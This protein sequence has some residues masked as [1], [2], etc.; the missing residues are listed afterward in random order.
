MNNEPSVVLSP[1]SHI[2]LIGICGTGMGA[3]AG[4]LKARGFSVSGSDA[5]AFPPMSTALMRLGI[6]VMEGF[7]AANLS[8]RPDL[9]VVGNVCR[10]DH[11]EAVAARQRGIPFASMA[12]VLRDLFLIHKESLVITGT[13]GKTTTTALTAF[14]LHRAGRDP[15]LLV[16]GVAADFGRGSLL[17]EGPEFVIEG[18]EYDSAYFEKFAKFL[19][20]APKAAVITSVE[21]DH[22]DIYPSFD[23]YRRAFG[24]FAASVPFP[25]P[26]AVFAGDSEALRAASA[27]EARVVRYGVSGDAPDRAIDWR[28]APLGDGRFEL[29]VDGRSRGIFQS[30]LRGRHN[31]RNTLAALI[32]CHVKA[33]IPLPVLSNALPEFQGVARRQQIIGRVRDIVIF[34]D[35]AHHP[36][37]VSETL[38]AIRERCPQGRLLA[39]FEPRSATACRKLHQKAYVEA[40]DAADSIVLAPVGRE[41]PKEERLSTEKLAEDLRARGKD[42]LAAADI[43]AVR[44]EIVRRARPGDAVVLL[45][46]GGFGNIRA[47]LLKEL[48]S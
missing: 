1:P 32:L 43:P 18:D 22:I 39:A 29:F 8:P 19:L 34:D 48:A 17:G 36:T 33:G 9:V 26:L 13:H 40:F 42:A 10:K 37:A 27:S 11:E 24:D 12:R 44:S 5:H 28:A 30:A 23:A 31:L 3:L 21:Y 15:S 45:S 20:Y 25:G 6:R 14:L 16:G 2:H 47:D 35:F 46:N 38:A 4:L 41:L 7:S